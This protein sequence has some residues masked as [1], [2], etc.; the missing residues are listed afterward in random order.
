M[1]YMAQSETPL[2]YVCIKKVYKNE[3]LGGIHYRMKFALKVSFLLNKDM[4]K[5]LENVETL[6][7]DKLISVSDKKA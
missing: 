3:W 1:I 6:E 2:Q 5:S 4:K 7:T